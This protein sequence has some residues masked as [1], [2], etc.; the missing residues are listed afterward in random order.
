MPIINH[1]YKDIDFL[2]HIIVKDNASPLNGEIDMYRRIF[3][4]CESSKYNWHFWHD[5]RLPIPVKGQSS[6]QIDFLLD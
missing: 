6:I 5:V 3:K 2:E 4:D 1:D